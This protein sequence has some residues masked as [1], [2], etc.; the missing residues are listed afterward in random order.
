MDYD[1]E[2]LYNAMNDV[3]Y[4]RHIEPNELSL[5]DK[6]GEI[7][8]SYYPSFSE[9][10]TTVD[11]GIRMG[12]VSRTILEK[13]E[14]INIIA[15]E[16]NDLLFRCIK[17]KFTDYIENNKIAFIHQ[18]FLSALKSIE[19]GSISFVTSIYSIHNFDNRYRTE[20]Y[21]EIYRILK[22][23]GVFIN[24]DFFASDDIDDNTKLNQERAKHYINAL[25]QLNKSEYIT[26]WV[27][28]LI[29]DISQNIEM[30]ESVTVDELKN[31][32]FHEIEFLNRTVG[33][34]VLKAIKRQ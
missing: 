19:E 13:F 28:H 15:I 24:G 20:L 10:I 30:K 23:G 14:N 4:V 33:E 7:I 12:S 29:H 18:D 11:L 5:A 3:D 34:C 2:F 1:R 25:M 16:E 32:N 27:T 9:K 21:R 31:L 17:P 26:E 6:I 8:Q 22:V